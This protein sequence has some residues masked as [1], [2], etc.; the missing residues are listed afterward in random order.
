MDF[1]PAVGEWVRDDFN[2]ICLVIGVNVDGYKVFRGRDLSSGA[3]IVEDITCPVS[4]LA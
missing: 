2:G 4:P 3:D 1:A